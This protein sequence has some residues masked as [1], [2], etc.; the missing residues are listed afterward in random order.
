[1]RIAIIGA[2]GTIGGCVRAALSGHADIISGGRNDADYAVDIT[3]PDSITAFYESVGPLDGVICTAGGA[4]FHTIDALTPQRN[5]TAVA[6]KL[7]GQVNLVLIGQ[8]YLN[9]GASFMLTAGIMMDQPIRHGTSAAMANGGVTAFVRSAA[10]GLTSGQRLNAV[11]PGLLH[12]S[13]AKYGEF[14]PG[15]TTVPGERVA[16]AYKKSVLGVDNGEIMRVY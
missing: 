14:F 7:L 10:A 2:N 3:Q 8:Y 6:S 13:E 4:E 15:F 1:M 12:E 16:L 11:S 9:T 5:A